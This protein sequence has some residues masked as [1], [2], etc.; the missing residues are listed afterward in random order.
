LPIDV[1]RISL[2]TGAAFVAGTIDAIGGGGGLITFPALLLA[3]L[4]PSMALGTNK[5]QSVFGSFA[6]TL[7]YGRAGLLDR[8]RARRTFP[9][10]LATATVGALLVVFGVPRD[11]LKPLVLGLLVAVAVF[12]AARPS[13]LVPKGAMPKHPTAIAVAIAAVIG[14]YDG[15][16][17]PGTGTFLILA[18]VLWLKDTAAR[19]S[20]DAK[21]VN[22]G[23]NLASL[24]VFAFCDQIRWEIAL[25]M[26]VAQFAGGTVGAGIAVKGGD[27]LVRRVVVA[28]VIAVTLKLAYDLYSA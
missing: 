24:I 17:G 20:A 5:G 10:A 23:S 8:P 26:A 6:A 27:V 14:A 3:G 13:T 7:R 12:L 9:A 19:A 18:F 11:A 2:L 28:V 15:F 4:S 21:V 22:F 25:P 1:L 16:F